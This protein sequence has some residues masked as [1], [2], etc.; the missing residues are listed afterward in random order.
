MSTLTD[1]TNTT[2]TTA[3]VHRSASTDTVTTS[4]QGVQLQKPFYLKHEYVAPAIVNYELWVQAETDRAKSFTAPQ[5]GMWTTAVMHHVFY[6]QNLALYYME[7]DKYFQSKVWGRLRKCLLDVEYKELKQMKEDNLRHI[8]E[9][10]WCWSQLS[11]QNQL[12]SQ[13]KV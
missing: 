11:L 12:K 6:H 8:R 7:E 5:L 13:L 2:P 1:T 3:V 4:P 9:C 10:R